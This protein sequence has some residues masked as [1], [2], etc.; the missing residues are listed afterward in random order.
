MQMPSAGMRLKA[1]NAFPSAVN[2]TVAPVNMA[3]VRPSFVVPGE[4]D[5]ADDRESKDEL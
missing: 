4:E 3:A 5:S 1:S 2:G